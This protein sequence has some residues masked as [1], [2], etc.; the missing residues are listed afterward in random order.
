MIRKSFLW[1]ALSAG[2]VLLCFSV[3]SCKRNSPASRFTKSN[4]STVDSVLDSI[5]SEKNVQKSSSDVAEKIDE[6]VVL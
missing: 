1:V 6:E 2:V 3:F 5:V 4:G